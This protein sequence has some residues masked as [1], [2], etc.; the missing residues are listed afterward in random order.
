MDL[1]DSLK[2]VTVHC[3]TNN[4]GK[5]GPVDIVNA[6]F[7]I[8]TH[9]QKRKPGVKIFVSGLLPRDQFPS[10]THSIIDLINKELDL[11]CRIKNIQNIHFLS[12]GFT[13]TN[14]NGSLNASLYYTDILHLSWKGIG[15]LSKLIIEII[16]EPEYDNSN[17]LT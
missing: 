5:D 9:I 15:K 16:K 8:A 7:F 12:P 17:T 1:P 4:V 11:C 10:K 13:W 3:G 6:L 14:Q 2:F